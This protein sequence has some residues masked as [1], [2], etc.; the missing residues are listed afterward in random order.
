MREAPL[1]PGRFRYESGSYGG[2]SGYLPSILGYK[3]TGPD[4]WVEH[5]CLVKPDAI[6]DEEASASEMAERHLAAARTIVDSGGSPQEFALSLQ[7]EG[8]KSVND[9]RVVGSQNSEEL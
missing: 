1:P 6:F 7:H 2:R 8:Y 9:F 3:E 4:S 5:L